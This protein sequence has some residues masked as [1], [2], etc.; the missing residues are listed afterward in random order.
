[1]TMYIS[2]SNFPCLLFYDPFVTFNFHVG[3]YLCNSSSRIC[4][5]F[6]R[7]VRLAA[8]VIEYYSLMV[9]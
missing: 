2:I 9:Y 1:M 8:V 7:T 4:D 5:K 6:S 3:L